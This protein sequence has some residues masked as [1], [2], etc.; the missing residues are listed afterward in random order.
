MYWVGAGVYFF[1]DF[2]VGVSIFD[3]GFDFFVLRGQ[4]GVGKRAVFESA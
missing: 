1:V 3:F 4:F 2:G